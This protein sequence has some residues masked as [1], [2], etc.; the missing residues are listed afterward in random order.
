MEERWLFGPVPDDGDM[1]ET[2]LRGVSVNCLSTVLLLDVPLGAASSLPKE[3]S[4][5]G[6][7][8]W[9][10]AEAANCCMRWD[11]KWQFMVGEG[12]AF[13]LGGRHDCDERVS[14]RY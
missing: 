7:R 5:R 14:E 8:D 11:R 4:A 10:R 6:G 12:V 13:A 1:E 9:V 2:C 3:K